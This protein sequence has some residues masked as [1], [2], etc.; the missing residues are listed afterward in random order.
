M[1]TAVMSRI[2]LAMPLRAQPKRRSTVAVK[3][4]VT[5]C[6]LPQIAQGFA[7]GFESL[8]AV[9]CMYGLMSVNE[10]ITHRYYQHDEISKFDFLKKVRAENPDLVAI[11]DG[12]GHVEHHAETLDDMS[13]RQDEK[14]KRTAM[15]ER[16]NA[17]KNEWRGTAFEWAITGLMCAQMAPQVYP[18][19]MGIFGWSFLHTTGFFGAGMILHALIWNALHPAMHGLHDISLKDGAPSSVLSFLRGS[20]YFNYLYD[21][22]KGHHISGGRTNYNVACPL[23]D[24]LVG[25]FETKEEW[26]ARLAVK[27]AISA[28]GKPEEDKDLVVAA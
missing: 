5:T 20:A 1:N 28:A 21:N 23:V 26:T 8:A 17:E 18:V 22:H 9:G 16:L 15:F 24:H 3:R 6:S 19:Y 11:L 27:A 10:Y 25:T 12:G 4:A 2:G 13:L 14:W 7:T